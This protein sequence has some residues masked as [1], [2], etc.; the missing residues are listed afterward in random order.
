MSLKYLQELANDFENLLETDEG[1]DVIIYAGDN[2]NVKEIHALSN[3][4]RVRSQYFHTVLSNGLIKKKDGKFIFNFPNTSPQFFKIIL[5]FIYCG[6][7]ELEKLQVS[8]I[9]KLLAV[10]DELK[11][12]SLV[13]CIQEFWIKYQYEFLRQNPIEILEAIYPHEIFTGLWNYCL[14]EIC[15]EPDILFNSD[16]FINLKE[17]LLELFLRRDDLSLDEIDV[18]NNLIKWCFSQHPSIQQDVNKWDKEEIVIME[19]TIHRFIPLIRFY[20]ISSTDFITKVYPFKEIMPKDLINNI[21]LFHMSP[22]V[23]LYFDI[24]SP[25]KPKCIHEKYVYDS[26]IPY[27][28]NLLYRASRDGNTPAVFH[29]KCDKKGTT[30]VVVK[31]SNS[32]QVVGG[33]NPLQW[34]SRDV[35]KSTQDSFIFSFV[36][37]NDLKSA[38][39]GYSNGDKFSIG[40]FM[41]YGPLFGSQYNLGYTNDKWYGRRSNSY[42][43][44]GILNSLMLMITKFFKLLRNNQ[45]SVSTL[46]EKF[47][48]KVFIIY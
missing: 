23:Q 32:N 16:K 1:Y 33:Y 6:K 46:M 4:L 27:D 21:L 37:K 17:P 35:W 5:R 42:P 3:I 45:I 9:L 38:K 36:N 15:S 20:H 13:T 41:N 43:D 24:E 48:N 25:R 40:D 18:W 12:H 47:N 8:E 28:F 2:E 31:I 10:I 22:Q 11:I 7:I 29:T 34:K 26:N 19:R 39:V 44:V 14:E 30:M